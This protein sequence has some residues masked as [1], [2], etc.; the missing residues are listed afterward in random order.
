M[1]ARARRPRQA[2]LTLVELMVVVAIVGFIMVAAQVT[3]RTDP[4][5]EDVGNRLSTLIAE[6]SRKAVAGGAVDPVYVQLSGVSARTRVLVRNDS[7]FQVA[8]IERLSESADAWIQIDRRILPTNIEVVGFSKATV[9]TANGAGPATTLSSQQAELR[10]YADGSCLPVAST[11]GLTLYLRDRDN[12][13][14]D[15]RVVVMPLRG[16]PLVLNS[17]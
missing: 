17:W 10:C 6:A 2:G 1:T 15:A 16:V 3:M 13:G 4:R 7:G 5:I 11:V 8:I 14:I 9:L 12:P